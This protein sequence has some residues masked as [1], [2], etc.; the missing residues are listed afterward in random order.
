MDHVNQRT[1]FDPVNA[2][3]MG[4]VTLPGTS[5]EATERPPSQLGYTTSDSGIIRDLQDRV[6]RLEAE[7]RG[8]KMVVE[9]LRGEVAGMKELVR[10]NE[11]FKPQ[12][13]TGP[14]STTAEPTPDY[15]SPAIDQSAIIPHPNLALGLPATAQTP[16]RCPSADPQPEQRGNKGIPVSS[17]FQS[18]SLVPDCET[19]G[20]Q[21]QHQAPP[22]STPPTQS[23][24]LSTPPTIT[25]GPGDSNELG[26]LGL[27]GSLLETASPVEQHLNDVAEMT[28]MV[29]DADGELAL[30]VLHSI[31]VDEGCLVTPPNQTHPLPGLSTR[32]LMSEYIH[33]RFLQSDVG[34]SG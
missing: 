5:T 32:S 20:G 2:M 26:P 18:L 13:T 29:V 7:L 10:P 14:N 6:A 4:T 12:E 16:S 3:Q 34:N 19:F 23:R 17:E 22:L 31:G 9:Y 8:T 30:Q 28:E 21:A 11:K 33:S 24:S 25:L 1:I 15:L 27:S